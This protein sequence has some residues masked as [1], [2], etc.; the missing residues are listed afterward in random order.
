MVRGFQVSKCFKLGE[1]VMIIQGN[2]AGESGYITKIIQNGS[3]QDSHAIVSMIKDTS[4]SD[5]TILI[6]NLRIKAEAAPSNPQFQKNMSIDS[7]MAG[8]LIQYDNL[9][10]LGYVIQTSPESLTV[11]TEFNSLE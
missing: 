4:Q 7:Y 1:N 2:R 6:N 3:G 10:K 11:L 8:D 9:K 5:L